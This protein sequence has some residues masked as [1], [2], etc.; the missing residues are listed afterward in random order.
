MGAFEKLQLELSDVVSFHSYN[1]PEEFEK[2]VKWLEELHRPILC[3]EYMA[4][5]RGSTFQT[6]LP[7]A[8]EH[9]IAAYNW[10]FV[11]GKTQTFLPWDSWQNPYVDRQ[12][13]V[14]FHDILTADGKPYRPEETAFIREITASANAATSAKPKRKGAGK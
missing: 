3:T 2:R 14:W 12:P 5:P 1:P 4:R 10:G 9:K 8:K 13:S 7:I 6:I 11:A